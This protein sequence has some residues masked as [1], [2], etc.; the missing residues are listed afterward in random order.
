MMRLALACMAVVGVAGCSSPVAL[1]FAFSHGEIRGR[2]Q[3]NGLR[4]VVMPDATTQLVEVDVRY[5]VGSR[6]DPPGKAG[7]AHLVE[8]LMFDQRP[9]GPGTK[10][11][12][13]VL[14]QL[15]LNM[16]AYTNWDTTHYMLNARAELLDA[17]I[18]IEA[19]RMFYGCQTISEDEFLREREVVRNEI[20]GGARAAEDLVPDKT[21]AAIYPKGHAYARSVGGDD[22]QLATLTLADAC[23]FMERYYAPARATVVVAGGIGADD[24][25]R[26]IQK[27]F[28][29]VAPR[30]PAPRR[31]VEPVTVGGGQNTVELDVERP[32][33]TVAWP[34]PD[35]RSPEG[36]AAQFG[37]WRAFFDVADRVDKYECAT[38]SFA[39]TMGGREAPIFMIALELRSLDKLEQCVDFVSKA[40]SN[41]AQDFE[42][43]RWS[44]L[45]EVKYRRKAAFVS[46]LE[47]LFGQGGRT[48]QVAD[49]V[50]FSTDVDFDSRELFVFHEL[51]KIGK[52]ER[53]SVG[54]AVERALDRSRA[55]VTVFKPSTQGAR[56]QQRASARFARSADD[57]LEEADVDPAEAQRPL[58]VAT[59]LKALAGATRF[60]L[61][62]GMRV[63]LLPVNAMPVVAAQLIFDAGDATMPDSP[64]LASAAIHLAIPPFGSAALRETGSTM[65]CQTTPDHTMCS[66][67]GMG[68]YI[69]VMIKAFER[70]IKVGDYDEQLIERWQRQ[71]RD[72]LKLR[73]P[74]QRIEF[75]RQQLAAIYGPAHPYTRTGVLTRDAVDKLGHDALSSFRDDHLTAANATLVI[76]GAF[77]PKAAEAAIREAFG[78]WGKGHKNAPV[79]RVPYLRT[80]PVYVGVVGDADP[81]VDV[82]MLYPSAA[83]IGGQEAAREVL[84][85]M[86]NAHMWTIRAK[87]G[88]TY[89]TSAW[90][91]ARV[92]ASAYHLG[93]AIDAP[94][95]GEALKAMRAG[96]DALRS[97]AELEV[98]FVRARRK[99]IQQLLGESTLST[100]MATRLGRIARFG[101]EPGYYNTLLRQTAALSLAQIKD[102]I[103]QELDP[104]NEVIVTL[105][106]R[107]AVTRAFAEAGITDARL[108]DAEAK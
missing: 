61:G 58:R 29:T 106:D 3:S 66:A 25:V 8:H 64:V 23:G 83:G 71:A 91:D 20:R 6:E 104:K 48:D 24:T 98:A 57:H 12:M 89:D 93:G 68:V 56:A 63:V 72:N 18:K 94:R 74:R 39:A 108:V 5:E 37:I 14:R 11:M 69:D 31:T 99:V 41:A 76:A 9:D 40:A 67:R 80:G 16:N 47:P 55:R 33:V 32:W 22:E 19:M 101:V 34:L 85:E 46:S 1:R 81:Q 78:G 26:S 73:R 82:A 86:L 36:E 96:V 42:G 28:A 43:G 17:L 105:G 59:E 107:D 97:G 7:L 15:T 50:Q 87:L 54:G 65:G 103:A 4:F 30:A 90:R 49:M 51:E 27:W 52:F 79:A 95:A 100:E 38:Q 13:Q 88:A 45:E 70:L 21:L 84:T 60:E 35:A 92:G 62:N 2:L 75:Q 77:D 44:Q 102:M 10:P 53:A